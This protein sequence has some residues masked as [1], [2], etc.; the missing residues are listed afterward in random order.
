M[1]EDKP[2]KVILLGEAGVGK[3]NIFGMVMEREFNPEYL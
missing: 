2:I 3:T 1:S